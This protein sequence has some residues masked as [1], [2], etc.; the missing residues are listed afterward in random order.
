MPK[1]ETVQ[2]QLERNT[3]NT[4]HI[5]TTVAEMIR[6]GLC[7]EQ[8][9]LTLLHGFASD[10]AKAATAGVC[11]ILQ[12]GEQLAA[13]DEYFFQPCQETASE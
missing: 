9:Y 4:N 10:T 5:A 1:T 11:A 3:T 2:Q 13:A 6:D 8:V 7:R 12:L